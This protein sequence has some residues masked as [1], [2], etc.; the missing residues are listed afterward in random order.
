MSGGTHT[1]EVLQ[2]YDSICREHY[3]YVYVQGDTIRIIDSIY[4][5][6]V[7]EIHDSINIHDTIYEPVEVIPPKYAYYQSCTR[8]MWGMVIAFTLII[9]FVILVAF[10]RR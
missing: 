1:I 9:A 6:Q 7:R 10:V 8:I 3:R 4:I 5:F 2:R